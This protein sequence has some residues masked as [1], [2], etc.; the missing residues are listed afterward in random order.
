MTTRLSSLFKVFAEKKKGV[1]PLRLGKEFGL[2]N[3]IE[4]IKVFSV[5]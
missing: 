4:D 3:K 1:L 2:D 5:E